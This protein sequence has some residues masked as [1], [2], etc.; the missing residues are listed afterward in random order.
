MNHHYAV[1]NSEEA[2]IGAGHRS[3][4]DNVYGGGVPGQETN[5]IAGLAREKQMIKQ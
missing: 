2:Q 5:G 4:E 1:T 3:H